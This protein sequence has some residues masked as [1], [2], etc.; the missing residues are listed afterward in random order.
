MRDCESLLSREPGWEPRRVTESRCKAASRA[1]SR[2]EGLRVPAESRTGL[3]VTEGQCCAAS[4]SESRDEGLRVP[5]KSPTGLGA[6]TSDWGSLQRRE[7][8]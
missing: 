7:S 4:R 8:G 5:A 2:D 6:E 3:E 1:A